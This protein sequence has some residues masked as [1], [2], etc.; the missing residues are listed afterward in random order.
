MSAKEM[1]HT[2]V[3]F[4]VDV[5]LPVGERLGLVVHGEFGFLH[6][7]LLA[8]TGRMHF[9]NPLHL[10]SKETCQYSYCLLADGQ[11]TVS[12]KLMFGPL[13]LWGAVGRVTWAVV[14]ADFQERR[15][16]THALLYHLTG[17]LA[18]PTWCSFRPFWLAV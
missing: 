17:V 8:S 14:E 7:V 15:G 9:T 6:Q 16:P 5:T 4:K 2:K 10:T 18:P 3:T 12:A 13:W 1:T 11:S